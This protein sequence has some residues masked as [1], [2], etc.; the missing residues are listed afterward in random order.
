MTQHPPAPDLP[1][2]KILL[3]GANGQVGWELRRTLA[4]LG[5]VV[6]ASIEGGYGPIVDLLDHGLL[7]Q[8][9]T[10]TQPD[11]VVNA[12][13]YTAVDKAET[14]RDIA[15]RINADA[16]G[17]LGRLLAARGIPIIHY[18]T[19]FV[20]SGAADHPY[21]EDDA[22]GPL[23]VYGET[24]LGGEL[25]LLESGAPCLI[26]RTSWVYG[27]RGANFLLTMLRLL[28]EKDELR[29]VDDQI[30]S[31]T[32]SRMLAEMTGLVLYRVLRGD[33]D[34]KQVGGL[35][36]L[37]GSGEVSWFGFA[38]A[39]LERAGLECRLLPIHSSDY[40]APAR[41][42]AYSVLGNH[43]FQETFGLYMPH[44]QDSLEQCLELIP[45]GSC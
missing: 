37:T 18:S 19:D 43:K 5:E 35:Y 12:A 22:V 32:W 10:D 21:R 36:H 39:I 2:P 7:A 31:P 20:F 27:A 24:K 3:I 44:W 42:P 29:I 9:V 6:A 38:Q 25:A 30:G 15:R 41:R 4:G 34:L 17:E 40:P 13:A 45:C 28:K 14:E 16:V 33:L 1:R 11:A 26:F 23:N 8:L